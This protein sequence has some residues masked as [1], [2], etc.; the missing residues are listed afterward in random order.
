MS[1][2][3]VPLFYE[4]DAIPTGEP[5]A[6]IVEILEEFL[7]MAKRGEI[8]A[9]GLAV[10]HPNNTIGSGWRHTGNWASLTAAAGTLSHRLLA[11]GCDDS[12]E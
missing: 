5:H 7:G 12:H 4:S 9:V 10:V 8:T 2:N 6:E 11:G 3:V 1:D